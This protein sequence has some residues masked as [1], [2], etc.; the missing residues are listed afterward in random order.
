MSKEELGQRAVEEISG[1]NMNLTDTAF[2]AAKMQNKSKEVA[3]DW[4]D[5]VTAYDST[6]TTFLQILRG[7]K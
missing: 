5:M 7:A 6:D 3:K 1:Y 2:I 4:Q